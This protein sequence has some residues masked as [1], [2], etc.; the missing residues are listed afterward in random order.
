MDLSCIWEH[1]GNDTLLYCGDFPGAFA[2]GSSLEEALGK[3]PGEVQAY[4][5]WAGIC[6]TAQ[7]HPVITFE[8]AS[9]LN[10]RDAD[11]DVLFPSEALPLSLEEY[12]KL[13]QLTL[14]SARDFFTL[15][16]S[17][18]DPKHSVLAS[19]K[20][21]YGPVPIT[22]EEMY[23]HTKQVNSYYF[24]EIGVDADNEGSIYDCRERGFALLEQQP[25]FLSA[26]AVTG[27]YGEAWSL[28]KVLRRFLWH[29]RIHA[30][31]MYRMAVKTFGPGCVPDLFRFQEAV[32]PEPLTD[33]R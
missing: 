19:R 15:F 12:E 32:F 8:K 28:R 1:N 21:F 26:A 11:S 18:P 16:S 24:G 22:G 7:L 27:S 4:C 6:L 13:K 30:R 2:R 9:E 17:L 31:A 3:I 33:S 14:S 29:D 10:I 20:T 23:L 5:R 25:G